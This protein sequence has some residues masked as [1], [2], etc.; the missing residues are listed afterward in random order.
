MYIL[1]KK[2][3]YM[4]STL[5]SSVLFVSSITIHTSF[6]LEPLR[7]ILL[8]FVLQNTKRKELSYEA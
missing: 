5:T 1:K 7:D 4:P 2:S 8:S 6:I 3:I